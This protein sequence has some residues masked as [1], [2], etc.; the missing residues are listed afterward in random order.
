MFSP[1]LQVKVL[2]HM[3]YI[4]IKTFSEPTVFRWPMFAV[5]GTH[6]LKYIWVIIAAMDF[7]LFKF[8]KRGGEIIKLNFGDFWM[9]IAVESES[10]DGDDKW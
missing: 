1:A 6:T 9:Q 2:E 7:K 5:K 8:H 3:I 4:W 10:Q